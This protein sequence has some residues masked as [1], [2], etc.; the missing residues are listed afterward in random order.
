MDDDKPRPP[1][2]RAIGQGLCDHMR[3]KLY[4]LPTLRLPPTAYHVYLHPEDY[5]ELEP[6]SARGIGELGKELTRAVARLNKEIEARHGG[7]FRNLL[8]DDED[9][10]LVEMP[11]SWQVWLHED[12][13][14]EV[15]RGGFGIESQLVP[16]P[17]PDFAGPPT[18]VARSLFGN[19]GRVS[20]ASPS[21]A[22]T[23]TAPESHPPAESTAVPEVVFS[24]EDDAGRHE[25]ALRQPTVTIGRGSSRGSVDVMVAKQD[26]T[27][28]REHCR[29]SYERGR[30]VIRDLSTWGTTVDNRLIPEALRSPESA[31]LEPGSAFEL[32]PT[33]RIGLATALVLHF[34][35]VRP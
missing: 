33:A 1:S 12:Q 27:I 9:N 24:Y 3:A 19:D 8:R 35:I 6:L 16:P 28:S 7:W 17:R 4:S 21:Q 2:L 18:V 29:I 34:R 26:D 5:N 20:P 25:M 14:G 22:T 31:F 30:F 15:A 32:P 11:A 23:A 10:L 13:N